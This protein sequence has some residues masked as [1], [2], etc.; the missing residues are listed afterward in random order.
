MALV[1]G[2]PEPTIRPVR[3]LEMSFSSSP[4][5]AMRLLHRHPAI[6]GAIALEAAGAA[7]DHRVEIDLQAA[8]HLAAEAQPP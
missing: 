7:V 1:D 5:S 2:P 3:G 4:A 8:M 6:A